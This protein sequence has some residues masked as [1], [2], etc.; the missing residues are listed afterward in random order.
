MKECYFY[1]KLKNDAVQC[2]LCPHNC[3]LRNGQFGICRVRKN[4]DGVLNYVMYGRVS[5]ASIDPVEKKPLFH[6]MP[7]SDV[8]S[9]AIAGCNLSCRFCQN[10]H[11]STIDLNDIGRYAQIR[12][13]SPHDF[14]SIVEVNAL[15]MGISNL[16]TLKRIY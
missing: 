16:D 11:I 8:Y 6:F 5:S 13:I 14:I 4:D 9:F 2:F 7:H 3:K 15:V 1:E 12:N 10:Y